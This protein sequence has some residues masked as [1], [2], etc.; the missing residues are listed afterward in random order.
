MRTIRDAPRGARAAG[1]DFFLVGGRLAVDFANTVH[2]AGLSRRAILGWPGLVSFL[3][4]ARAVTPGEARRLR[5]FERDRH[6]A[7]RAAFRDAV[8]LRAA[9]QDVLGALAGGR[10]IPRAAVDAINAALRAGAGHDEVIAT[11]EG[12]ALRAIREPLAPPSAL[13]PIAR[14]AAELVVEGR[15][16]PV[17]KCAN[18]DCALYFYDASPAG[19]RRWCSMR[20]CGNRMKVAAFARRNR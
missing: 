8:A 2:T 12:W 18:P 10:P 19:K 20:A 17:R 13:V 16:A 14:S 11:A 7:C 1:P 3:E 6:E 4:A 5:G 15:R 9:L